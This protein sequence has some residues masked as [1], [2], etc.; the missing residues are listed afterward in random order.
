M[1]INKIKYLPKTN[2]FGDVYAKAT[3]MPFVGEMMVAAAAQGEGD[4]L[5]QYAVSDNY[6]NCESNGDHCW[7]EKTVAMTTDVEGGIIK[8]NYVQKYEYDYE[9]ESIVEK[10]YADI[11]DDDWIDYYDGF[12]LGDYTQCADGQYDGYRPVYLLKAFVN[13]GFA[14]GPLSPVYKFE[15]EAAMP[16]GAMSFGECNPLEI[17]NVLVTKLGENSYTVTADCEQ[18]EWAHYRVFVNGADS[19]FSVKLIQDISDSTKLVMD[20]T[21]SNTF[22]AAA[23]EAG[24]GSYTATAQDNYG[25][26]ATYCHNGSYVEYVMSGNWT[27]TTPPTPSVVE[28]VTF[29]VE[30][31]GDEW[32]LWGMVTFNQDFVS[33]YCE[34]FTEFTLDLKDSSNN[35]IEDSNNLPI[36]GLYDIILCETNVYEPNLGRN[37]T[38]TLPESGNYS[39]VVSNSEGTIYEGTGTWT[40]QDPQI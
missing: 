4:W 35:Y 34:T 33:E 12:G 13:D 23:V 5:L 7:V 29:Y 39:I 27:M 19:A 10:S 15:I 22:D 25:E 24:S 31:N 11:P 28:S 1:D 30:Q 21:Y 32:T 36:V 38:L 20:T 8:V 16:S 2:A 40:Y 14:G 3:G 6:G 9:T 18:P 26:T 17:S 37:G